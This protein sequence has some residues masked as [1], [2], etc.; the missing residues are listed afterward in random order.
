MA[1]LAL[2]V[3]AMISAV[4]LAAATSTVKQQ[5]NEHDFRQC[6]LDLQ[7]AGELIVED[8]TGEKVSDP[9]VFPDSSGA[10]NPIKVVETYT[11]GVDES[12]NCDEKWI[13]DGDSEVVGGKIGSF[14][15]LLRDWIATNYD[16]S[17]DVGKSVELRITPKESGESR[18]V[19][20]TTGSKVSDGNTYL[21]INLVHNG[22]GS[23]PGQSSVNGHVLHAML[24]SDPPSEKTEPVGSDQN[25]SPLSYKK[26][27]T[28]MWTFDS[29]YTDNER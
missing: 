7:S 5:A 24:R 4:I 11:A 17:V 9:S 10:V 1:L 23:V 27:K 15:E 2:L 18:L 6:Q 12:G 8:I 20:V 3:V 29:F 19:T 13:K 16:G 21:I 26:T 22:M 25:G 28:Y 14:D